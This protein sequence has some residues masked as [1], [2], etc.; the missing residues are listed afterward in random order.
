MHAHHDGGSWI[1]GDPASNTLTRELLE[2]GNLHKHKHSKHKLE[3]SNIEN[4]I[5]D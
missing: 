2:L 3:F 5:D 1:R 4:V